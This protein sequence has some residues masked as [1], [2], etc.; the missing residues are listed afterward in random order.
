VCPALDLLVISNRAN[1]TLSVF[2]LPSWETAL[3]GPGLKP[4]YTLGDSDA[5]TESE[6]TGALKFHFHL[7]MWLSGALAFTAGPPG[8]PHLLVV[9][10]A[11]QHVV[12]VVDVVRRVQVG[13]VCSMLWPR[14]VTAKGRLVAVSSFHDFDRGEH[15]VTLFQGEPA[16]DTWR[17]LRRIHD[18]AAWSG[19]DAGRLEMPR[20]LRFSADGRE[21][22]VVQSSCG[23][24]TLFRVEDGAILRHLATDLPGPFDL[25]AW[26]PEG[27]WLVAC[28]ESS[29]VDFVGEGGGCSDIL[30]PAWAPLRGG[31][32]G[33]SEELRW[34]AALALVPGLGLVVREDRIEGRLRV[35][36]SPDVVAVASMSAWRVAWM[37]AAA[38][39]CLAK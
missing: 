36:A 31:P 30:K 33:D 26:D 32:P 6:S 2:A 35:F 38:R 15:E 24:L 5:S 12:H 10:D 13:L 14:G 11:G 23:R 27:G 4:A 18:W 16:G 25:E 37:A 22:A 9:T 21:V 3:A 19:G 39:A 7:D 1:G 34:P 29:T 8:S 28:M 20:G 17:P